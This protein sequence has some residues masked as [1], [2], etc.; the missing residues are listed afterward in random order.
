MS[1]STSD[2]LRYR[3]HLWVP[4][5]SSVSTTEPEDAPGTPVTVTT[6]LVRPGDFL[7][8]EP[9]YEVVGR[10]AGESGD[11]L[12]VLVDPDS[13]TQVSDI[14]L[15]G[16]IAEVYDLFPPVIE[17]HVV[18]DPE[19]AELA[20]REGPEAVALSTLADHYVARLEDGF[21]IV[22]LGSYEEYGTTTLGS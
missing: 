21:R 11:I 8:D 22:Y 4:G 16:I 3:S 13:A 5:P 2:R 18:D 17:A 7:P 19:A 1:P 12:I 15:H 14:D 20:L 9:T 10:T 6:D